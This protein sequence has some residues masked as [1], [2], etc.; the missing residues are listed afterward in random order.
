MKVSFFSSFAIASIAAFNT[1]Q[2]L[3]IMP[4]D[5][6]LLAQID[7]GPFSIDF[8]PGVH[9][10]TSIT[11]HIDAEAAAQA[12]LDAQSESEAESDGDF[13]PTAMVQVGAEDDV[14][15]IRNKIA[16]EKSKIRQNEVKQNFRAMEHVQKM[17][18]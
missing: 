13:D 11:T 9:A 10:E 18:A 5:A 3:R 4:E 15:D 14:K 2:A 1:A 8:N 16:A 6:E 17:Q 7:V 12:E